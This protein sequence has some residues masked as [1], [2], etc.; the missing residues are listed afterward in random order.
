MGD[1]PFPAHTNSRCYGGSSL[2]PVDA[3]SQG[4]AVCE[5]G[6]VSRLIQPHSA[7]PSAGE[8]ASGD[9]KEGVMRS[10]TVIHPPHL[11]VVLVSRP[12]A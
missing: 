2:P 12:L 1:Q 8:R 6:G 10:W 5:F 7:L 9:G 4:R 3:A 11:G